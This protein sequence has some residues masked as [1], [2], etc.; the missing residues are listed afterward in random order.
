M[1]F[2]TMSNIKDEIDWE[3]PGANTP[4]VRPTF[5]AGKHS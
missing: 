5:L 2:I 3:F 4:A 1:A